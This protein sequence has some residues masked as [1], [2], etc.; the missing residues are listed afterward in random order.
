MHLLANIGNEVSKGLK[1]FE[2]ASMET[3]NNPY[4]FNANESAVC[5]LVRTT[6]KAFHPRGSDEAGVASHFKAYLQSLDRPAL[7]L[8]S[9]IGSRFNILFTNATA[10]YHHYKDL[11]N[12][13]KFW[14]IPNR[15]LQAVTY[16]LAQTPLK[17]GVRALGIMDKLLIEPLDTLIKQEGSIL[18]VNGHLVHLQ[19][20]LETLC[21]DATAM[22]DEQPLF[23]DVPIKRDDM[24]DA[25]FAPVSPV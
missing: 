20:K 12:F 22:M 18:D 11:E 3:V 13:L 16:D 5:R 23:Q 8:Q 14:P 9:F 7:K 4:G 2:D 1:L 15:L 17:A 25:L 6:C 24:Y 21:R 19:K 10:T